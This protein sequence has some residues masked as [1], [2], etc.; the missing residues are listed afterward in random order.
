MEI[1][2]KFNI[3]KAEGELQAVSIH[4]S[5]QAIT[6]GAVIIKADMIK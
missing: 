6:E 4:G 3:L 1:Q 2:E 5:S